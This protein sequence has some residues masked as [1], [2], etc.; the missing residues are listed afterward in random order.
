MASTMN[1]SLP[2][3]MRAFVEAQAEAGHYSVSEYIRELIRQKMRADQ[4][5]ELPEWFKAL[6]QEM[7]QEYLSACA[8]Q[9]ERGEIS[10]KSIPQ[11]LAEERARYRSLRAQGATSDP[12]A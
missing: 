12:D 6:D 7:V 8:E 1:I 2:E 10:T 4:A 9:L 5:R 3:S 11:I